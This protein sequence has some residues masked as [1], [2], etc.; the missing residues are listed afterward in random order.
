MK[1]EPVRLSELR[2]KVVV[3]N[4][5]ATW[6]VPCRAE[7]P[8]FNTMQRDM[9][10]RGLSI[11]GVSFDATPEEI[12]EFQND[13]KQD[14]TLLLGDDELKSKLGVG[15]S[16]PTTLIIDRQGRIRK[17]IVGQRNREAFE[18]E[19]KPLLD[20]APATASNLN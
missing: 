13:I 9:E 12:K 1:G 20:E 17:R 3:L 18:A 5:W 10:T 19:V 7:I 2:G 8:E 4:F 11:V 14:Y 15:Q 6:C 16:F